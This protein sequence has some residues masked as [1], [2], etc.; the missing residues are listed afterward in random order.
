MTTNRTTDRNIRE[1]TDRLQSMELTSNFAD[2][3][4]LRRL[5]LAPSTSR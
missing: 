5:D 3:E 4:R 1:L 2:A